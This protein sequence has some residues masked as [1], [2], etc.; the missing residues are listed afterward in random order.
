MPASLRA[1]I[2][3]LIPLLI[4]AGP[5]DFRKAGQ[6]VAPINDTTII[7]EAEEF[8]VVGKGGWQPKTWGENYFAATLAN[9]FL[10]RKAF[11]GAPEQ[12]EPSTA[13]IEVEVP[14][15]GTYLALIR[16]EAVHR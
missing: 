13:T 1:T 8:Q 3:A 7:A 11:L 6:P 4:A 10:S 5:A 12:C 16:Y 9:T 2:L 14:K 15:A